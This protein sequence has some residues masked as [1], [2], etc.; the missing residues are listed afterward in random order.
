MAWVNLIGQDPVPWLLDPGN[1]STRYLTLKH[2]F[3]KPEQVLRD[4][5]TRILAWQPV[6]RLRSHWTPTSYWGRA[7][8]PYYGGAVGNFGTLYLLT[9]LGAPRFSEVEPTCKSLLEHGSLPDG[10]F[11][12]S[13]QVAAPWLSYTGMA[14]QILTHFGYADDPRTQRGWELLAQVINDDPETLGC[15]TTD[16]GCR[17]AGIK[18]LRALLHRGGDHPLESDGETIDHLCQYLLDQ[19]YDW[20]S[21]EAGWLQPRFP[22]YYDTDIIEFTHLLAHTEYR[23]APLCKT[24]AARMIAYH[25]GEG[26][27]LKTKSTPVFTIERMHQ[28]SRWL[29]FEAV[30]ALMLIHGDTMYAA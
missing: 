30:H 21:R 5:Q 7:T 22:R 6:T 3:H 19:T 2:I 15:A 4:E 27:W 23:D 25:N 18:A 26:R 9:Q 12:P 10:S 29:T 8:S 28:P 11:A 20:E 13:R 17:T 24:L 1:P 14:L 16:R